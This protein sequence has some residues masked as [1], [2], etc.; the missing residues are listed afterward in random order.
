LKKHQIAQKKQ[1][2]LSTLKWEG[3]VR[4]ELMLRLRQQSEKSRKNVT[5]ENGPSPQSQH[6]YRSKKNILRK[7]ILQSLTARP[8]HKT[9]G[10]GNGIYQVDIMRQKQASITCGFEDQG[11]IEKNPKQKPTKVDE[12]ISW[13]MQKTAVTQPRG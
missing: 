8:E 9:E 13:H 5:Y 1:K 10:R 6:R 7:P 12:P 4:M 3:R 2:M 11:T